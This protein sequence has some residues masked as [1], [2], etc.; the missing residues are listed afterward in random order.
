[1]IV[2]FCRQRSIAA[3]GSS[4]SLGADEREE[5]DASSGMSEES[6]MTVLESTTGASRLANIVM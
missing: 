6:S 5:H 1:M 4:A 2:L 3:L